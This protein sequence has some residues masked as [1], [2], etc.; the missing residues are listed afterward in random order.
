LAWG[1]LIGRWTFDSTFT[2]SGT[3]FYPD[4]S[5]RG[6]S[7]TVS[8]GA[9]PLVPGRF[10]NAASFDGASSLVSSGPNLVGGYSSF[11]LGA[12]VFVQTVPV[13]GGDAAVLADP[14][15]QAGITYHTT[16]KFYG[17]AGGGARHVVTPT[18]NAPG[19]WRHVAQTYNGATQQTKLYVDGV[20]V[21]A[22]A[23]Q[24][25][26]TSIN[27]SSLGIG[28]IGSA[29]FLAGKVDEAFLLD[30]VLT[31]AQVA[32]LASPPPATPARIW[33]SR[34]ATQP[35]PEGLNANGSLEIDLLRGQSLGQGES[36]AFTIWAQPARDAA[37][38]YKQLQNISLN[39]VT[40]G[41]PVVD[42]LNGPVDGVLVANPG[43]NIDGDPEIDVMRFLQTF[44]SSYADANNP[45]LKL[46]NLAPE[47]IELGDPDRVLGIVAASPTV[48]GAREGVGL[49]PWPLP[50]DPTSVMTAFGPVYRLGSFSVKSLATMGDVNLHLQL[51]A[52]GIS[53]AGEHT[54]DAQVIFAPPGQSGPIYSAGPSGNRD[55]TLP[56]DAADILFHVSDALVGDYNG[57][58]LVDGADLL[59]WQRRLG[60]MTPPLINRAPNATGP[61]GQIDLTRWRANF[62]R[63]T[64]P[65]PAVSVPEPTT[66]A[67]T[68]CLVYLV[69]RGVRRRQLSVVR[70]RLA[71]KLLPQRRSM[72][73][74][75]FRGTC[76][77]LM[78]LLA[79]AVS[80]SLRGA[81]WYWDG[82]LSGA[83]G[84]ETNWSTNSSAAT[85]DPAT[86]PG[87]GDA[88]WFNITTLNSPQTVS[89]NL[90]RSVRA[91][92]FRSTGAVV[93]QSGGAGNSLTL[94]A[95]VPDE[96]IHVTS[97]AGPVTISA[98]VN[99]VATQPWTNHSSSALTVSG[100]VSG[101]GGIVKRGSGVLVLSS[102]ANSYT[103]G[104]FF[105]SG[106]VSIASNEDLGNVSGGLAFNGGV[107]QTTGTLTSN[108]GITIGNSGGEFNVLGSV[109][110]TF[111]GNITP[112]GTGA[113]SKSGAGTLVLTGVNSY[114]G[115]TVVNGGTLRVLAQ[116]LPLSGPVSVN[117]A[118]TVLEFNQAGGGP[119]GYGGAGQMLS[120]N[121]GGLT[122]SNPT[123]G[124]LN[125][126][127]G[128]VTLN[129]D[130][131]VTST[132]GNQVA[133]QL[134]GN[135]Q[136][137]G[138]LL[139][140]GVIRLLGNNT[141]SGG[142]TI[143]AG[144][145]LLIDG[146]ESLGHSG[147]EVRIAGG[148]LMPLTNGIVLN[149]GRNIVLAASGGTINTGGLDFTVNSTI[150]GTGLTKI[151]GGTL[152]LG[153][154][155][156]Y[157]GGTT[158]SG[159][160]LQVSSNANLGTGTVTLTSGGTLAAS[161]G[162][163]L[164]RSI[165]LAGAGG[166]INTI[167]GELVVTSVV[168]GS[169][170]LTKNGAGTLRLTNN[171]A[172]GGTLVNA[173]T[174]I[175][176]TGG[177]PG[178]ITNNASVIFDQALDGTYAGVMSGS[179][180]LTMQ[181]VGILTLTGTNAYTGG[182][183]LNGGFINVSADANLGGAG[184][185][186]TF[187]GG[188]LRVY[189]PF[190]SSRNMTINP[191][192]STTFDVLGG[193][194]P[195]FSG[196]IDGSGTLIKGGAGNLNLTGNNSYT[197]GANINGGSIN[198]STISGSTPMPTTGN[199]T[200]AS[201]AT[202]VL[203]THGAYGGSGQQIVTNGG[204]LEMLNAGSG[205]LTSWNGG[206]VLNAN[207]TI[208]KFGPAATYGQ[209][210]GA[211][212]G[213]AGLTT[214]GTLILAGNNTYTGGT[215]ISAG[216]LQ[217]GDGG[218]TGSIPGNIINNSIL[219]FNRTGALSLAG[220]ITGSGSLIKYA[221]GT[222]TL[223]DN[224]N[225]YAGLNTIDSG[226]LSGA[227]LA[228][229]GA[230][231]AFGRGSF[232][233]YNG[234][235]L[236]YTGGTASTNRTITLPA[237]QGAVTVT[238]SNASL[239][240]SG[241]ISGPGSFAKIGSG[242][243]ILAGN[244]T[245]TGGTTISAGNLQ[246]GD[247]GSTGSI[248]GNIINNSIL[249]FNRTGA[250]SLAGRITGSGSLIKYA[251][252]TVTL[253]DNTNSYAGLNTIDSGILSGATLADI[254]ADSAFGRGS[255]AIYNG[256]WLQYTGGTASTN[257]TITLPA[258]QGAVTVTNSNA[259]LTMSGLISGPGSFAKIGSGTLILAGN[260]TYTGGTYI[261][262]GTL[263]LTNTAGS[264]TG[265]GTITIGP[266]GLL[267]I[268]NGGAVSPAAGDIVNSGALVFNHTNDFVFNRQI[269]GSGGQLFKYGSGVLD[270]TGSNGYTGGTTIVG[271]SLRGSSITNAGQAS[272][273]GQGHFSI[274]FGATLRYSG[275]NASTNRT[276]TLGAEGGY[277]DVENSGATLTWTGQ[278]TGAGYFKKTGPGTL[279]LTNSNTNASGNNYLGDTYVNNGTL[280]LESGGKINNSPFVRIGGLTSATASGAMVV[281]G[282]GSKV[283]AGS[284]LVVGSDSDGTLMVSA[285]G[286]AESHNVNIGNNTSGSIVPEGIATITG[287]G[288]TLKAN[289]LLWVGNAAHGTLT[290]ESGGQASSV[291]ETIVGA[292]PNSQGTVTL[293]GPGS[294]LAVTSALTVGKGGVGSLQI[295]GGSS[296]VNY[297]GF[298][299]H[300]GGSQGTV[301]VTGAGS[302]WSNSDLFIGGSIAAAGGTGSLVVQNGGA[303]QVA[304]GLRLWEQGSVSV[305]SGG[306][307]NVGGGTPIANTLVVGPSGTL[308]G[309]GTI[310]G[311]VAGP[312]RIA[313]GNS[314]GI[315]T[316]NG[317]YT[318]QS[319]SQLDIEINGTGT[320]GV[321]YDLL[322]V[323]GQVTLRGAIN[324]NF[325][326][327]PAPTLGD[328]VT[329]IETFGAGEVLSVPAGSEPRINTIGLNPAS[330]LAARVTSNVGSLGSVEVELV[331]A[332]DTLFDGTAASTNWYVGGDWST[333]GAAGVPGPASNTFVGGNVFVQAGV[334]QRVVLDATISPEI[335]Q[336]RQLVVGDA[337]QPVVLEVQTGLNSVTGDIS[338]KE[339]GAV[340]LRGGNLFVGT[341]QAVSVSDS[342]ML[343]GNGAVNGS[344]QVGVAAGSNDAML[345]PGLSAT[346]AEVGTL[347]ISGNYTQ[348][349]SGVFDVDVK[350][351]PAG[352]LFDRV[353]IAGAATIGGELRVD[354]TGFAPT[355]GAT[356]TIATTASLSGTF[357]DVALVG[358]NDLY[359]S[360]G[361]GGFPAVGASAAA[362]MGGGQP[363]DIRFLGMG[364]ADGD[365]DV[366]Q[367]DAR[368]FAAVLIKND[369]L[370]FNLG[371][372]KSATNNFKDAFNFYTAGEPA[373][374]RIID[375][376][377]IAGFT[378]RLSASQGIAIEAAYSVVQTAYQH[379]LAAGVP[380]PRSLVSFIVAVST[381]GV[382]RRRRCTI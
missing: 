2:S 164:D 58:Q 156:S 110:S 166:T 297:S 355:A 306:T 162:F 8:S 52:G 77:C 296:V 200:V 4:S 10:G 210:N 239:T 113:L 46:D 324:L 289:N 145:A 35:I 290:I 184:G 90:S 85:P 39:L 256:G 190:A 54:A 305:T 353:N 168:S 292:L 175:G 74:A 373:G 163:T 380:E 326:N 223:L 121:G 135:V 226:I 9:V 76:F 229:I 28:R 224:T 201:G 325:A 12:H 354:V 123:S 143:N 47:E 348:G 237:G 153:G 63:A 48:S 254:G 216:N 108:R 371:N 312:G 241:L 358:N 340:E 42:I 366:D 213:S 294:G 307:I 17:Y 284:G 247:G 276:I 177:L 139:T 322:R 222:V 70:R 22:I 277:L 300:D 295:S 259:S 23:S 357:S 62:G 118:G 197:G 185:K 117:G 280:K 71:A 180:S 124:S 49:G 20:V 365:T 374:R 94:N 147:S 194:D 379:A 336:V 3:I 282:A 126:W 231:S 235:W 330:N 212:S 56:T 97:T 195:L 160:A 127:N 6:N 104:T 266:S 311:S 150:S 87:P 350:S 370:G 176:W 64:L 131:L 242:T 250:L 5:G 269:D 314:P 279:T 227:T 25:P 304:N 334:A 189:E 299:A 33:I 114:T 120:M 313:P 209:I 128:D 179:G 192:A 178:N 79:F 154:S 302:T 196:A 261:D 271:G 207:T 333:G 328:N 273:F 72:P 106:V 293:D 157:T 100:A 204:N 148:T 368:V 198:F 24:P 65:A 19:V 73:H 169:G 38:F 45:I 188:T 221:S 16:Q 172:Y 220:R 107:L 193:K 103:G 217:I 378:Q 320:A 50:G 255:F 44:D 298:V 159:G 351:A 234:G 51:G 93:I 102:G 377:D 211:I 214:A 372:G 205:T 345:S 219:S 66:G 14:G 346:D 319:A 356:Y 278:L 92:I 132:G 136:G 60:T 272:S 270:L 337:L 55:V 182:T 267:R 244:N 21:D 206:M 225:S 140:N 275:P 236:Q 68:L 11:T 369:L 161:T 329:F 199:I 1:R 203:G 364:D 291:G 43:F 155:N 338:I 274:P 80:S 151:D 263:E 308:S 130:T 111:T 360:V 268:G 30:E 41:E 69:K 59:V 89:L 101:L 347:A 57:D 382:A 88:A 251:S 112:S 249:S 262:S 84:N 352:G 285:G 18:A 303:V 174:L 230:D 252:G 141:Y 95:G 233:I 170:G 83:W 208:T 375:F 246:I 26:P 138:R 316:I 187:N 260:N 359:V 129:N 27:L 32:A 362:L 171:N 281:T 342:G 105:E 34:S 367:D 381:L 31:D 310:G 183:F 287:A 245:Y 116:S 186:L 343:A 257:R 142:T 158:I 301:T 36:A 165:A 218:S 109:T 115:G 149:S 61:V 125:A 67:M 40:T 286:V 29:S 99:L 240:M 323:G 146:V 265:T 283:T 238:N 361:Y 167:A 96:G 332:S 78:L 248:P 133:G 363:L 81:D 37:G 228:D 137:A 232:A 7:F 13:G 191:S 327:N 82:S 349:T 91:L 173:G 331:E 119:I 181:N 122:F 288:S 144:S 344:V 309:R 258:G 253:L 75:A 215:T 315:L 152:T 341:T 202:L 318:M 98:P 321:D 86:L 335:A 264:A 376:D 53:N 134:T 15:L 339:N 317:D 243:L